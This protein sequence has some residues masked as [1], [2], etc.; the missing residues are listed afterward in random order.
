MRVVMRAAWIGAW[1]CVSSQLT[2][3]RPN[4]A[5]RAPT[6]QSVTVRAEMAT[7]LLQS[8]RY[9]EAAREFRTLLARDPSSFEYRLGLAHALAWGDHPRE[10]ERELVQLLAKRPGPPGLD[11]LLRVV[12][13]ASD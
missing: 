13:A 4:R 12:R 3:Q 1:L 9:D 11:S 5:S 2:A 10:A 6:G 7:V 8:G